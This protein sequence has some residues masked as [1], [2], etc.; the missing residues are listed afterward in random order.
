MEKE[1]R[2]SCEERRNE[3][4]KNSATE[5]QLKNHLAYW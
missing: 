2:A 1:I 3:W 4:D 5:K